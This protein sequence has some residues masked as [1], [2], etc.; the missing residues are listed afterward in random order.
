M[1]LFKMQSAATLQVS[2]NRNI[3]NSETDKGLKQ[4][5]KVSLKEKVRNWKLKR[6]EIKN[7]KLKAKAEK[8]EFDGGKLDGYFKSKWTRCKTRF[9][10]MKS[11]LKKDSKES[12]EIVKT[13]SASRIN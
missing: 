3:G 9:G 4:K 7:A 5:D 13:A 2:K 6:V 8:I 12:L 11:K 10:K 1:A